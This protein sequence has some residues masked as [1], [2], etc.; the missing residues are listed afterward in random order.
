[1]PDWISELQRLKEAGE[2]V[3]FIAATPGRAERTMELLKE[4]NVLAVPIDRADDARYAAVL[5]V[6]GTISRGLRLPDAALQI[7]AETDVFD[8][9]R[10][11]PEKRR[12]PS[13]AFLSDL[14]ERKVG[15]LVVHG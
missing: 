14:S 1:I 4:Y 6:L 2:T 8:E 12:S 13:K 11:V 5:V 7:Y 10:R 9:A 15:D 3:L